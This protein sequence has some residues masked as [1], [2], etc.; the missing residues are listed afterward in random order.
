MERAVGHGLAARPWEQ[1]EAGA[2]YA[3]VRRAAGFM[4]WS[5]TEPGHGCPISMTY[6]A[7][8]RLRRRRD[9]QSGPRCSASTAYDPGRPARLD[10]ARRAGWHGDDR[11]AGRL[12]R[13]HQRHQAADV[14]RRRVHPPRAQRFTS[15]PMN[16]VFLLLAQAPGGLTCFVVPRCPRTVFAQPAGRRPAQ[17]QARQ[18]AP[19][20]P[21]L[22]LDG[23]VAQRLGDEGRG[24]DHHRDGRRDPAR[25]RAGVDLVD[26]PSPSTRPPGASHRSAFGSLLVEKPLM[27]NVL[28]DLA[29]ETE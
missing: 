12:G 8:P 15:A 13:P 3:H 4:A 26:A 5:H 20:V 9:R 17:G 27:Q 1:Q 11:E 7:V 21:E 14:G 29:V 6:A 19:R 28:A 22:E 10:Q 16:D 24:A 25:L 23:T 2:P 18:P